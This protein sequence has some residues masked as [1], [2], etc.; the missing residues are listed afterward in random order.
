MGGVIVSL[1]LDVP[2]SSLYIPN[3]LFVANV[4]QNAVD[5]VP[6][7][8]NVTPSLIFDKFTNTFSSRSSFRLQ[9]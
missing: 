7:V 2:V 5:T 3:P 4:D 8:L 9:T 1:I 6:N